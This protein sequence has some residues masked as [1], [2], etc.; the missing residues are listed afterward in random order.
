[1]T[2]RGLPV[3][4]RRGGEARCSTSRRLPIARGYDGWV[5]YGLRPENGSHGRLIRNDPCPG[6]IFETVHLAAGGAAVVELVHVEAV[7]GAEEG[8]IPVEAVAVVAM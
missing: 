1:M 2:A 8:A 6:V 4:T 3:W 7:L 5:A